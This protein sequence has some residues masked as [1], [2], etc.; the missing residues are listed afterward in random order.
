MQY[1]VFWIVFLCMDQTYQLYVK[2]LWVL[3]IQ[4]DELA[5][6]N[7][8]TN[9]DLNPH[10]LKMLLHIYSILW[11]HAKCTRRLVQLFCGCK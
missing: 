8:Q 9:Y 11:V 3:L 7:D 4:V 2:M 5:Q 1:L 10:P 6:S